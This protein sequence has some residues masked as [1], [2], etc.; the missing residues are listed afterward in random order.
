MFRKFR[1]MLVTFILTLLVVMLISGSMSLRYLTALSVPV[2]NCP[3][4]YRACDRTPE[5][6]HVFQ[7]REETK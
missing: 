2:C 1:H 4:F 5:F 6:L 3:V 7:N